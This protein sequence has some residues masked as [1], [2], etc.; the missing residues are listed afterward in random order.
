MYIHLGLCILFLMGAAAAGLVR[1]MDVFRKSD[2]KHY[3]PN[4]LDTSTTLFYDAT[5]LPHHSPAS[6]DS[7]AA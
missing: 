3:V 4:A 1:L 5:R 6:N 2:P 7:M